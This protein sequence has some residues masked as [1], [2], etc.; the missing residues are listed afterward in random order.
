MSS[1]KAAVHLCTGFAHLL[2]LV[3]ILLLPNSSL[4]IS[5][6]FALLFWASVFLLLCLKVACSFSLHAAAAASLFVKGCLGCFAALW[7]DPCPA[8]GLPGT[9]APWGCWMAEPE[10]LSAVQLPQAQ[11]SFVE[12]GP[13]H[14][15]H[16]G[17]CELQGMYLS[18]LALLHCCA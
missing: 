10:L 1:S 16:P 8:V 5:P 9:F 12:P 2:S 15:G 17:T 14:S 3:S 7:V 13:P 6:H 11:G 18:S 4:G